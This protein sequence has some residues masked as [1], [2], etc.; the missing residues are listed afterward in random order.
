MGIGLDEYNII[1]DISRRR[2]RETRTDTRRFL[3]KSIDW[4]DR[5]IA[6]S[7]A[8]GTGK[9]TLILQH[10][11][12]EF[13]DNPDAAIYISLDNMWFEVH[14]LLDLVEA[15]YKFGGTH[16]FIDEIHHMKDCQLLIKNIYDNYPGLNIVYTGSSLLNM[17]FEGGDLSRRQIRYLLPGLSFREYIYF[18]GA[19]DHKPVSLDDLIMNHEK[20]AEE[21]IS[22]NRILKLF[23]AYLQK[24]Y[25][26][27]YKEVYAG[28]GQRLEQ[29][30]NQILESDYP[31]VASI[32]YS[33]VSKIKKMLY[34]LAQNCPQTPNM[35][36]LYRQLDTDRNQGLKMLYIL[37]KANLLSLL[38]SGSSSLK[39]MGRPDKIYCDNTN[40]MYS[41]TENVN[42]G[43]RRETFFL[44]Q[45][46]SAGYEV[47][48]P[49]QGDFLINGRYLF[50]VGGK[51]KS[52]NQIKDIPYSY[53][54]ID[55]EETCYGNKIPLW[56]FGLL[57]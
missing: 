42:T 23:N 21:Y 15:H 22:G 46:K 32:N 1:K 54:A 52:F 47:T 5:L 12:E 19:G 7:G 57:Y 45:L 49:K 25:Y 4:R 26:P 55:E 10:I 28:Y 17:D 20:I 53:I 40:I 8:R 16:I 31:A 44:N 39:N 48:Y 51:N 41:L 43:T 9:T 37:D 36:E 56:M 11:R 33:T 6:I 27:F 38:Q 13:A 2:I 29:V 24:G 18:E 3:I 14:P 35:S 34:I 50:E 30:I